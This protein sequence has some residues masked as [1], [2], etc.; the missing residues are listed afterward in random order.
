MCEG[1][2][3]KCKDLTSDLEVS[4]DRDGGEKHHLA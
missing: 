3:Y 4:G 1:W 2:N